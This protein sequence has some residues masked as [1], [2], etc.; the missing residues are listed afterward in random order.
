MA[1]PQ[2]AGFWSYTHRD[3]ELDDGRIVRL[4]DHIANAFEIITGGPL[5]IFIDKRSIEWGD[6][7]RV[8][9][10]SAL[11]GSTFLIPVITPKFLQS[12]ECR[13]EV[14]KFAGHAA[15]LG[16]D[17]LL[18]PIHYVDVPELSRAAEGQPADEVVA[19]IARRQWV[20]WRDLRLEDEESP[21]Y[22]QAVHKLG[23]RL[24]EI[25]ETAPPGVPVVA[26]PLDQGEEEPP[27]FIEVMAEMEEALPKWLDTV[28]QFGEVITLIG[29][30]TTWATDEMG[31]SDARGG[32]FAGRMRVTE[33]LVSRL[34]GP[35]E[36]VEALGEKYGTELT[37]I[38]PGVI[39]VIRRV[40][41]DD[42]SSEDELAVR[43][44]FKEIKEL[45]SVTNES[46]AQLQGFS[47]NV[48]AA[49]QGSRRLRPQF[50][51][52]QSAAQKFIDGQTVINEWSRMIDE[53]DLGD[54]EAQV[55]G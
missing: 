30:E 45:A 49:A 3:D 52:I 24:S 17:E 19:L 31:A 44:F 4:S 39:G 6:A 15:S 50:K 41:E 47:D 13:R 42:L 29:E 28:Q 1:N 12:Q 26:A 55:D 48:A 37:T 53:V 18:L 16:L 54:G 21:R 46:T 14:I 5:E 40:S 7:W 20:D 9:L 32:G 51:K 8:R 25:L 33:E 36:T 10:D 23:A 43:E 38:D 27:G 34:T 11:T 35:V 2:P 22:R